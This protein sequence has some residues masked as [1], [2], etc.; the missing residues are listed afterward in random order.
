MFDV[1]FKIIMIFLCVFLYVFSLLFLY[2]MIYYWFI[3]FDF[4][5]YL[6]LVG[7]GLNELRFILLFLIMIGV[8]GLEVGRVVYNLDVSGV[9]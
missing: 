4:Y 6:L 1:K 9:Y 3:K 2:L 8:W 7:Y 5:I